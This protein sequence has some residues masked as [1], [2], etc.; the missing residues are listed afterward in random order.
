MR[1]G[2]TWILFAADI[3]LLF[4]AANRDVVQGLQ[5]FTVS[6]LDRNVAP[7]EDTR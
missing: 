5:T 4:H 1:A 3:C 6:K 7:K 2:V